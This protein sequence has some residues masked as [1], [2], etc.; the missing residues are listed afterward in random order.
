MKYEM[1]IRAYF[2]VNSFKITA[3]IFVEKFT[4]K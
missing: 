3:S 2:K 4:H 1:G